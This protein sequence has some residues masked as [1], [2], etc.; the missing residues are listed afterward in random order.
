MSLGGALS[1]FL[2]GLS[3]H[4]GA[5]RSMFLL[6]AGLSKHEFIATGV[7]IAVVVDVMRLSLYGWHFTI[8]SNDIDWTLVTWACLTAFLG[9]FVG[10]KLIAKVT[11]NAVQILVSVLLFFIGIG[12]IAGLI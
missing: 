4:Q 2:G 8:K 1:G 6:K 12:L 10:K 3:G 7:A 5:F 11:I 9:T